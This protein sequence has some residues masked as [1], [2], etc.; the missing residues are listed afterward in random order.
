MK[1][2]AGSTRGF[3][4]IELMVVV[5]VMGLLVAGGM[6]AYSSFNNKQRIRQ[7]ADNLMTELRIAQK[8]A[9][10]GEIKFTCGSLLG[11]R[12]SWEG[13]T[14]YS[15][16]PFCDNSEPY[17]DGLGYTVPPDA[18]GQYPT[19]VNGVNFTSNWGPFVFGVLSRGLLNTSGSPIGQQTINLTLP[20]TSETASVILEASGA[21]RA[22][23]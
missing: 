4:L 6:A 16:V 3:T 20:G 8:K 19:L 10:K 9:D 1:H 21:I 2:A 13:A 17:E 18:M 23:Y 15:I 7:A 11:Y 22:I 5:V 14:I 12:I